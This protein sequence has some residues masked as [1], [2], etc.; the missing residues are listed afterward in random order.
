MDL[1]LLILQ[2]TE[3]LV[4]VRVLVTPSDTG[5]PEGIY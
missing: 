3:S 5:V 2:P 4:S 1:G